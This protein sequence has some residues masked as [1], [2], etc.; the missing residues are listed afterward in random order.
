MGLYLFDLYKILGCLELFWC[1]GG[2]FWEVR[3]LVYI[4]FGWCM[5]F[6]VGLFGSFN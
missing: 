4:L 6:R 2:V 1:V 5:I 3:G